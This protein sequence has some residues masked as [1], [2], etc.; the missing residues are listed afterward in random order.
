M[1]TQLL[2]IIKQVA[3]EEGIISS[4]SEDLPADKKTVLIQYLNEVKQEVSNKA[5][6]S[7]LL[8]DFY[9]KLEATYTTGT[10]A[11]DNGEVLMTITTGEFSADMVGRKIQIGDDVSIYEIES[12]VG[13]TQAKIDRP[14]IGDDETAAEFTIFKEDYEI[15]G[16]TKVLAVQPQDDR[17]TTMKKL[18]PKDMARKF[19]NPVRNLTDPIFYADMGSTETEESLTVAAADTTT[20]TATSPDGEYNEYYDGWLLT[21]E[22]QEETVKIASF[23]ADT[24]VFTLEEAITGQTASDT[25]VV[26]KVA[27]IVRLR[28]V[29]STEYYIKGLGFKPINKLVND[30]D[31]DRDIA[32]DYSDRVLK[33]GIKVK[34]RFNDPNKTTNDQDIALYREYRGND[35]NGGLI[36]EIKAFEDVDKYADKIY[37]FGGG[38][39][40]ENPLTGAAWPVYEY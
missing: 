7:S 26:R 8:K 17:D 33:L 22:S 20:V 16:I 23:D 18:W 28:N 10:I 34:Y 9:F 11:I 21:N 39:I 5:G 31:I 4:Y 29:P 36:G 38:V 15:L 32:E 37:Q 2:D 27:T 12:Y 19:P 40:E 14:F 6:L 13:T 24:G 35:G 1:R 25:I 30:T 3:F